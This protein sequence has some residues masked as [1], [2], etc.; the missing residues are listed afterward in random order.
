ML[1]ADAC[2]HEVA[3]GART[4]ATATESGYRSIVGAFRPSKERIM[5]KIQSV[6][7]S[8]T[9]AIGLAAPAF[10]GLNDPEVII[11]RFPGVRE[12][13]GA[14]FSGTS[15]VFHC[16]NFSGATETLR[17]V[18]RRSDGSLAQ[19][20]A[21]TIDH[22]ATVTATTKNT[23]AYFESIF[24]GTG[25]VAQG[26]TAIAATSINIICTA[27]TIDASTNAPVGVARRGIRFSPVPGSQE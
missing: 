17:F 13:G 18:T 27:E 23:L 8:A 10:A 1:A 2:A 9:L 19:N 24:L 6:L 15:T 7:V 16:T 20:N 5:K 14:E 26:T 3:I 22:L 4:C 12:T 21:L 25:F 11:Y